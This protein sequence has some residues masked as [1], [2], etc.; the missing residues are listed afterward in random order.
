MKKKRRRRTYKEKRHVILGV[1]HRL[2]TKILYFFGGRCNRCGFSDVRALQIDHI[3]G[4]GR[5]EKKEKFKGS[6]RTFW[7][8]LLDGTLPPEKYQLLCANC[9]WIKRYENNEL[10]GTDYADSI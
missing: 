8:R 9:N 2:R 6:N 4:G 7:R 1:M 10:K 5:R 3:D